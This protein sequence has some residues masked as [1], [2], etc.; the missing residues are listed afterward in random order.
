MA[1]AICFRM[2]F[3]NSSF[4]PLNLLFMVLQYNLCIKDGN[5]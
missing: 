2:K 1:D 4:I 5:Y 3:H